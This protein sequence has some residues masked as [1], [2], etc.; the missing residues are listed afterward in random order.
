MPE[1]S[2]GGWERVVTN[3]PSTALIMQPKCTNGAQN[4]RENATNAHP[5]GPAHPQNDYYTRKNKGVDQEAVA[6][7]LSFLCW[8]G[9]LVIVDGEKSVC[10]KCGVTPKASH[11]FAR[12]LAF[13]IFVSSKAL[14]EGSAGTS[15]R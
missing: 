10:L 2:E 6:V 1:E 11:R 3:N 7:G 14:R 12:G 13:C 9:G 8:G 15:G 5:L 4:G